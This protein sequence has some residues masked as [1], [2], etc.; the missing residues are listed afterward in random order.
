MFKKSALISICSFFFSSS[1]CYALDFSP[2]E[3]GKKISTI[4]SLVVMREAA[5][6][7]PEKNCTAVEDARINSEKQKESF[8]EE[9]HIAYLEKITFDTLIENLGLSCILF[10][11][12]S[13]EFNKIDPNKSKLFMEHYAS[14]YKVILS[15]SYTQGPRSRAQSE[16]TRLSISGSRI[17][18]NHSSTSSVCSRYESDNYEIRLSAFC[19]ALKNSHFWKKEKFVNFETLS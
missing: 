15:E 4:S 6:D 17:N 13:R 11:I 12:H 5:S 2:K 9:K 3:Y 8:P 1:I 7:T 18:D 19:V 16:D 10:E 14:V